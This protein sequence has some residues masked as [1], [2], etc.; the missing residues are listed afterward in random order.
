MLSG[1][2]ETVLIEL[3]RFSSP[4]N[5]EWRTVSVQIP[6]TSPTVVEVSFFSNLIHVYLT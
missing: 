2:N 3:S 1:R 4:S 5:F 6:V